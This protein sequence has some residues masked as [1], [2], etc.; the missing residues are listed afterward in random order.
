V[1][2]PVLTP[3]PELELELE[4]EFLLDIDVEFESEAVDS[5]AAPTVMRAV[6]VQPL[7]LAVQ[8]A[9][10]DQPT[11]ELPLEARTRPEPVVLRKTLR[12]LLALLPKTNQES[13]PLPQ[14]P[15]LGSLATELPILAP[16]Q[17]AEMSIAASLAEALAELRRSE[18]RTTRLP[19]VLPLS[20]AIAMVESKKSDVSELLSSFQVEEPDVNRGLCRAIKEMADLDLTPAPFAALIR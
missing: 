4:P 7:P 19:E 1:L 13:E 6:A 12:P 20:P 15:T 14:T 5:S 8:D 11:L 3:E 9:N 16:E 17:I 2:L 10:S 18:E